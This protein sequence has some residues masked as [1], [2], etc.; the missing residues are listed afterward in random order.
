MQKN[1]EILKELEQLQ[2]SLAKMP[3]VM[4]YAVPEN[5]FS[6]LPEQVLAQALDSETSAVLPKAV[7]FEVPKGYFDSLPD[8]L[9]KAAKSSEEKPKT[10]VIS[11]GE[12]IWKK[13]RFAAA[14]IVLLA[15]GTGIFQ[16]SDRQNSF[17]HKLAQLPVEAVSEYVEQNADGFEVPVESSAANTSV[18]L[19][20]LT[21]EEI[22][23]YL[24]ETG[25]Q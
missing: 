8:Q 5:Y 4:P 1:N 18:S 22:N 23:A 6:S 14:A 10:K 15:L 20:Q 7:P 16:L 21:E 17:E 12:T 9:L 11:L 2:S 24:D 19:N 25:W 3:R 13:T